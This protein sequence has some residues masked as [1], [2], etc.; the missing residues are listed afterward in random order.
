MTW[1][2]GRFSKVLKT[3]WLGTWDTQREGSRDPSSARSAASKKA[4][5]V[6]LVFSRQLLCYLIESDNNDYARRKW[7]SVRIE[8]LTCSNETFVSI[9]FVSYHYKLWRLQP[10]LNYGSTI[11]NRPQAK[12]FW[13]CRGLDSRAHICEK[14]KTWDTQWRGT[15]PEFWELLNDLGRP[16]W[17]IDYCT[18][19]TIAFAAIL[20]LNL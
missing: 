18:V 4:L 1:D 9:L 20:Y 17:L 16:K 8:L 2:S 6:F 19:S 13:G 12:I 5:I 10:E 7:C 14:S 11:F 15:N 3:Q